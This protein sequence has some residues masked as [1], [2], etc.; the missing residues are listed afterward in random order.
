M[1]CCERSDLI[2]PAGCKD[3]TLPPKLMA[4]FLHPP[5]VDHPPRTLAVV[6]PIPFPQSSTSIFKV[7]GHA[8]FYARHDVNDLSDPL[9]VAYSCRFTSTDILAELSYM[10]LASLSP[11]R[12]TSGQLDDVKRTSSNGPQNRACSMPGSKSQKCSPF[13]S[14]SKKGKRLIGDSDRRWLPLV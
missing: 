13:R 10:L 5:G 1:E 4:E 8:A 6:H 9:D 7:D 11:F 14:A 12:S 3:G 2:E